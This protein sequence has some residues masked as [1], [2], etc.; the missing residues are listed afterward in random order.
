MLGF[1]RRPCRVG[2][3]LTKNL[4]QLLGRVYADIGRSKF[5]RL[6]GEAVGNAAGPQTRVSAGQHVIRGV[7]D[8][9][10]LAAGASQFFEQSLRAQRI[11]FLG[12]ETV[13]TIDLSEE[14]SQAEGFDDGT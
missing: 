14:L 4:S 2:R 8:H 12:R 1:W 11:G 3:A 9:D 5:K 13:A 10:R 7:A 6:R